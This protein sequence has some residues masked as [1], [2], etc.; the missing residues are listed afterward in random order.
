M[1]LAEEQV[2]KRGEDRTFQQIVTKTF[3]LM[4]KVMSLSIQQCQQT[5]NMLKLEN[6]TKNYYKWSKR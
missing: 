5:P 1:G 2:K 4:T 6:S 3:T